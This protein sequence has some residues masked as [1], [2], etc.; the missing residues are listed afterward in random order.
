VIVRFATGLRK[1]GTTVEQFQEHWRTLHAEAV[2]ALDGL[3]AYTQNH[4]VLRAD[5]T[6]WLPWP[7]TDACAEISFPSVEAMDAAFASP[8]A[9]AVRADSAL[10]IEPGRGGLTVGARRVIA[11]GCDPDGGVKLVSVFRRAAGFDPGMFVDVLAGEYAQA[12]ATGGPLRHE[13][14]IPLDPSDPVN[15]YDAVDL[16]WFADPDSAARFA[17]SPAAGRA[18]AALTGRVLGAERLIARPVRIL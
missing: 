16:L 13:Q 11:D 6:P 4:L 3:A 7:A 10:F 2:L 15:I 12:V 9:V 18:A 14:L 17:V 1:P 8:D 5:G